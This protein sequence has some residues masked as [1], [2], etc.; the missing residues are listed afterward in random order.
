MT[1][2]SLRTL[3]QSN[4][5]LNIPTHANVHTH[6]TFSHSPTKN[7]ETC[8]WNTNKVDCIFGSSIRQSLI[9]KIC[10]FIYIAGRV[11]GRG[12]INVI[13]LLPSSINVDTPSSIYFPFL[14]LFSLIFPFFNFLSFF[15]SL[16]LSFLSLSLSFSF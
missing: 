6:Y 12:I 7:T 14:P 13:A 16:S 5:H 2:C 8:S 10:G 1:C 9:C 15:L 3:S 11:P 4:S